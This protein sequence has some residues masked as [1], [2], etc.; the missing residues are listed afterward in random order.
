M[1]YRPAL[2]GKWNALSLARRALKGKS[3]R[4]RFHSQLCCQVVRYF[5][6]TLYNSYKWT[7]SWL[8]LYYACPI[9]IQQQPFYSIPDHP[10]SIRR[11]YPVS[12][13]HYIITITRSINT[14]R[15]ITRSHC[16]DRR[17]ED[18]DRSKHVAW[19]ESQQESSRSLALSVCRPQNVAEVQLL[20]RI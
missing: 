15:Y 19:L 1:L 3:P 18:H 12:L 13:F 6:L 20:E 14:L 10:D 16:D 7:A 9:R 11:K 4:Q 17:P 5:C 2:H 8:A